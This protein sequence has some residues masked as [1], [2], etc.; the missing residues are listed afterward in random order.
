MIYIA[1]GSFLIVMTL[2]ECDKQFRI[3]SRE[4]CYLALLLMIGL[5]SLRHGV[6]TD[7]DA[8]LTL[9]Q[10]IEES[11][12]VEIGYSYINNLFSH[13]GIHYNVFLFVMTT[14]CIALISS[15]FRQ[16][17]ALSAAAIL[18]FY[19]DLF[20]YFN[21]SG[22]RQAVAISITCFALRYAVAKKPLQ[23][24]SLVTVAASFHMS[25]VVFFIGYFI[26]RS[27]PKWHYLV[28]VCLGG[29]AFYY[30]LEPIAQFITEHTL[31]NASYYLHGIEVQD[32][33]IAS[34]FIGGVKRLVVLG[35][36]LV[37]WRSLKE[38]PYFLY[39][40]NMYIFG[41]AIYF[42]FYTISVDIGVRMSSYF[43]ILDTLLVGLA[44][45]N[46]SN[47]LTRLSIAS[48]VSAICLYKLLGYASNPYYDYKFIF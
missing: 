46:A 19:S 30:F 26:P 8:Y 17:G 29:L 1:I 18:M 31:K 38:K 36:V 11:S 10:N 24:F 12:R 40:L 16:A 21:L 41:L 2:V 43:T 22:M 32:N 13:M 33:I 34:Y 6:G 15:F 23:F 4:G 14:I 9:Y 39:L 7:W 47:I 37:T 45:L 28:W 5:A 42:L 3:L 44:I 20:L 35:I 27:R 25:A 48:L